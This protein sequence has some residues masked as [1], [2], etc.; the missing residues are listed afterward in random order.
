MLYKLPATKKPANG[1]DAVCKGIEVNKSN[2]LNTAT[3]VSIMTAI[4]SAATDKINGFHDSSAVTD[5]YFIMLEKISTGLMSYKQQSSDLGIEEI[6]GHKNML[7]LP[8]Q[9]KEMFEHIKKYSNMDDEFYIE[10]HIYDVVSERE[11]ER[12]FNQLT[13]EGMQIGYEVNE[14]P[15]IIQV[16]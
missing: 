9:F 12:A 16:M 1:I 2:I 13:R 10:L 15:C 4:L 11:I 6:A 8:Q 5:P 7:T 3:S 14:Y